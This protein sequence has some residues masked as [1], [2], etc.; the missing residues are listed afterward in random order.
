MKRKM[1]WILSIIS[2]ITLINCGGGSSKEAKELLQ[3]ILNLVGIPQ[4]IVLNICQNN[5]N[6]N[7]C[8]DS[9]LQTK[10][11]INKGDNLNT[12]LSKIKK[13]EDGK[14]LLE[15]LDP[16][17]PILLVLKDI[18]N[19]KYDNGEF[20]F[21]FN[22]LKKNELE[23]E[24][25]IFQTMI[26]AQ[27]LTI[28]DVKRARNLNSD[29]T[30]DEFYAMLLKTLEGNLNTL[31]DRL[32]EE[33]VSPKSS[34]LS[35]KSSIEAEQ[36]MRDNL[37]YMS[38]NLLKNGIKSEI[39][40]KLNSCN[41]E[42]NCVKTIL[43]N[44]SN[45]IKITPEIAKEIYPAIENN[46]SSDSN[47]SSNN[48]VPFSVPASAFVTMWKTTNS[49]ISNNNQITI[50]TSGNGYNY[51]VD[52]GDGTHDTNL[53]TDKTHT[54]DGAGEYT[55]SIFG[56]F[57]RIAFGKDSDGNI[58]TVESDARKLI[59]IVKWG[60]NVWSSMEG[61]FMECTSLEGDASDKPNLS[62]V[63]TVKSMFHGATSFNSLSIKDWDMSNITNMNSMFAYAYSFNQDISSWNVS[64]V[65][66]MSNMFKEAKSF[67]QDLG[68]W[69]I[70]NV[71]YMKGMFEG[72]KLS[73]ENYDSILINWNATHHQA[74]VQF[75]AGDSIYSCDNDAQDARDNLTHLWGWLIFDGGSDC[76]NNNHSDNN[77]P[78]DIYNPNYP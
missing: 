37:I 72:I 23:K 11:S 38:Q 14:Y 36:S 1:I 62:K 6:N 42:S 64:K 57:P 15:T 5:N 31:R 50:P 21:H 59:S 65:T 29:K 51:S 17:K 41:G 45:K 20:T 39:P 54:Y 74:N 2:I 75:N 63:N 19:V 25:S 10:V 55:I 40:E 46:N 26:D 7:I 48:N 35:K 76:S 49:G 4:E 61:A 12:I 73:T 68:N 13:T 22:G 32:S 24:L 28:E 47:N 43:D 53:T 67:N 16:T 58:E 60:D 9:E 30:Q 69:K 34:T 52:W 44:L 33:N 27:H 71:R 70:E 3:R 78:D 66:D 77:N 8:E 18:V 56:K